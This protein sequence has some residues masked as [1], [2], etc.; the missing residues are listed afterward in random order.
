MIPKQSSKK[1]Q[2]SALK[3]KDA[4]GDVPDI[5]GEFTTE[6]VDK[7]DWAPGNDP[8]PMTRMDEKIL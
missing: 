3:P 5:G 2:E 6:G 8:F 4:P 1:A 7:D